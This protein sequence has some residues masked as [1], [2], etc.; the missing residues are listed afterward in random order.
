MTMNNVEQQP[1]SHIKVLESNREPCSSVKS[2]QTNALS[3]VI[4]PVKS[5]EHFVIKAGQQPA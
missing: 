2:G 5:V 1:S 4:H 3:F